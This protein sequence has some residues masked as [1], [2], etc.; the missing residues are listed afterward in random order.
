MKDLALLIFEE[1]IFKK[2]KI[3]PK[4][5]LSNAIKL[6][7]KSIVYHIN[8]NISPNKL[9]YDIKTPKNFLLKLI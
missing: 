2:L 1:K 4:N 8:P 9:K 3:K 6:G 7:K 5:K